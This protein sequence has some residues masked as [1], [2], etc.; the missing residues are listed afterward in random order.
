MN[1]NDIV[2]SYKALK[3]NDIETQY[4]LMNS[5]S[6]LIDH[7]ESELNDFKKICNL[8]ENKCKSIKATLSLEEN[9]KSVANGDRKAQS[10]NR[11]NDAYNN[12]IER[13][14]EKE[15]ISRIIRFLSR[16]YY[17]TKELF[18][19]NQNRYKKYKNK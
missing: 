1:Y 12:F 3:D 18:F 11:Y 15:E 8:A 2:S 16:I 10:D 9:I 4:Q 14:Y 13:E 7:Y 17:D 5:A 6:A 19:L